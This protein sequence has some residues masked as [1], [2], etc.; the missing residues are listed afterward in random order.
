MLLS[1][2]GGILKLGIQKS[3]KV[4]KNS[5]HTSKKKKLLFHYKDECVVSVEKNT[6]SG[7]NTQLLN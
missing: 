6:V 7:K 5:I 1:S 2:D 3:C 4:F